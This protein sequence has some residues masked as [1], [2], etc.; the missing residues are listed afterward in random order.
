MNAFGD[1]EYPDQGGT[2]GSADP[3]PAP[4][5]P[6]ARHGGS[7]LGSSL[8]DS[9]GRRG[10]GKEDAA[11]GEAEGQIRALMAAYGV[12]RQRLVELVLGGGALFGPS[13][14]AA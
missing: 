6:D 3:S 10:T 11:V 8:S 13:G 5:T 1:V 9:L 2:Q 12:S 14:R 4:A 7:S